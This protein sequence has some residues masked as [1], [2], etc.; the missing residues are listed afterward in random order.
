MDGIIRA[1]LT[2]IF[3]RSAAAGS[4]PAGRR[5][6]RQARTFLAAKGACSSPPR[7]PGSVVESAEPLVERHRAVGIVALEIFVVEVVRVAVRCRRPRPSP[8]TILSKPVWP[9]AGDKA[10]MQQMED[11]VD[12]VRRHDPVD[13]H[14]GEIEQVLDRM[15]RQPR[16]RPGIDVGVVQLVHGPIERRPVD[17]PVDA[18]RNALRGTAG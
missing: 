7:P 15:H 9:W 10:G 16:P 8:T 11:R 4:D 2:V 12:R 5:L 3:W 14:A 17:Q 1:W 13:E 6:P 18:D